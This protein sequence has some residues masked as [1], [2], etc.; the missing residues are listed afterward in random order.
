[1]ILRN[2]VFVAWPEYAFDMQACSVAQTVMVAVVLHAPFDG[3][4]DHWFERYK[5]SATPR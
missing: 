1:M 4:S 5:A 3:G 2:L